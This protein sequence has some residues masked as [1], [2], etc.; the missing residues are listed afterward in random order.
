M[1]S[2]FERL[3]RH[4]GHDVGNRVEFLHVRR[5]IGLGDHDHR[6]EH[7]LHERS[8]ELLVLDFRIK[9]ASFL[10]ERARAVFALEVPSRFA[11]RNQGNEVEC[12]ETPYPYNI[13]WL[14][15][16]AARA[17]KLP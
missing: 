12:E 17:M 5:T 11:H 16:S 4:V 9:I 3:A 1:S 6:A 10:V 8:V 2:V 15:S 7:R 14:I 13:K